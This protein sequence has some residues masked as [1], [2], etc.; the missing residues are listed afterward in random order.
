MRFDFHPTPGGW[1]ISE[2]NS[3]VPGGFTEASFFT[4][5]IAE[6]FYDARIVGNPIDLWADGIATAANGGNVGLLTAPGF[7]ED[8]QIVAYLANHL[9]ARGCGTHLANPLQLCWKDHVAHLDTHWHCGM[10]D[11]VVRFFQSEWL[12]HLPRRCNWKQFFRSGRTPIGNPGSAVIPESKRFP[13]VWDKLHMLLPTWQALLPET[14]DPRESAWRT[15][16]GWLLKATMSNTGDEVCIRELMKPRDWDRLRWDVWLRPNHWL[17][18][19]RFQSEPLA[20]PLGPMHVCLGVYSINGK[21][22]G[23]YGRLAGQPLIDYSAVDAAV[24]VDNNE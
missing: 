19:R 23:I 4:G 7:M 17:A 2:V 13:L 21:V 5:L 9:R 6:H 3:D 10:L 16:D 18:Q 22:A 12:P 1:R 11:A 15:D 14:C 20:T 24:L 8:H